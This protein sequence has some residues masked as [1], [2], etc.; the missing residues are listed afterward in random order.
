MISPL[1]TANAV[2]PLSFDHRIANHHNF[3]KHTHVLSFSYSRHIIPPR[4]FPLSNHAPASPFSRSGATPIATSPH[5]WIFHRL[6]IEVPKALSRSDTRGIRSPATFRQ[7]W[8]P[9]TIRKGRSYS[10]NRSP[11]SPDPT[12]GHL[13]V[14]VAC[15]WERCARP[16][17]RVPVIPGIRFSSL[18]LP[19]LELAVDVLSHHVYGPRRKTWGIEMT[20][21]NSLARDASSHS[22]LFDIVS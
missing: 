22:H 16:T 19:G 12:V 5:L 3:L 1:S 10:Q 11:R 2:R 21:V 13:E 4:S 18:C 7:P 6:H 14:W 17:F 20:I 15:C 9:A 8:R